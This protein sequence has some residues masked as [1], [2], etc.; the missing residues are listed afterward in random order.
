MSENKAPDPQAQA[1]A[2][3]ERFK[4]L[5]AAFVRL[6]ESREKNNA[7]EHLN[8]SRMWADAAQKRHG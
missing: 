6:P 8:L 7:V 1:K 2:I 3:A 4:A 5:H